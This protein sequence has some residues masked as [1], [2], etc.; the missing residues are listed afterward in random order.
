ML[1]IIL[2]ALVPILAGVGVGKVLDKTV[3]D[4]L[5]QYPEGGISSGFE[6]KKI[7]WF[8]VASIVGTI[9]IKFIAKKLNIKI[10]K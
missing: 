4:K 2:R 5:P 3:A 6:T 9:A 8:I 1:G 10:L 7:L